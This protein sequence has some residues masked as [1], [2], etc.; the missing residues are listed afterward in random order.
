MR[1]RKKRIVAG[2][3]VAIMMA[4]SILC[5]ISPLRASET[6][7]N[8][9]VNEKFNKEGLWI[10]EIYQND[11]DRS[12]KNNSRE[13]SGYESIRLYKSTTDLMEFVEITSTYDK[14]VNFNDT[15]EFVYNDTALQ[16]STMDGS[17][18]VVIQPEEKVVLWNY[19]S[20]IKTPIPTEAEFREEMRIPDDAVVLKVTSEVNWGVTSTF[21]LRTKS[22]QNVIST[23][24]ATDKVDTMD[25]FSVEL[26]IPDIGNEMQVY[27]EMC[28]PSPGYIYSGQ[29][30]GLVK[31]KVPDSQIAD[32]V[33]ITEVRPNDVNRKSTYGIADDL[34][35][36]VEIVNTT[37]HDVDLNNE[38]QFGYE[39]KEGSRK[40]LELNH[41]DDNA[42]N[43]I[44][45]SDSCIIPAGKT[46]V[47][48]F[49]RVKFL[50]GYTSF[51]T[52]KEFRD[53]YKISD[54]V[55]V[56]LVTGQNGMN[57]TNRAV[58]L[59]KK[60]SDG[61][62]KLVSYY[63]YVG[64]SD[65]KDNKSAELM[66]NPEGPEM[67][68]K[69]AN[70]ATSMGSVS[71]AQYTY[72][73]DDGSA[74]GLALD[75]VVPSSI[76][77]G[78]EL[79]V[80]FRYDVTGSL[81]RTG[82]TTYYRFDGA[83]SWYS[84][85]EVN[86]RVPNLYESLIPAD[87]LFSHD[88]VEFYV[89][90]DNR[91]RSTYSDIYRVD[92]KKLNA[93]DGI[94][95]NITDNEQVRGIVSITANDGENNS[96]SKIYV[97]G[98]QRQTE[99]MLEDG[100]YFTFHAEG[101]DS[102]F[103]NAVTT[104]DN[105]VIAS[106]GKWQYQILDGQ[107]IHIDNRYFKYNEE[108]AAYDVTLRFWAGTY[109]AT[110]DEYLL[111]DANREDFTVKNLAL[112]LINGNIY[113]PKAIGPDNEDTSTKTNLSTDYETVHYIGDST[114]MCPYMDVSFTIPSSEVT[115]VG[116]QVDTTK[117][118]DG[119]HIL[120]VTNGTST[121]EVTF[122]VDN[123][124]PEIELGVN[125]GDVLRGNITLNP[126]VTETNTLDEFV[127]TLDGEQISDV[128]ETTSYALG[129]GVHTIA[130]FAKDAAGNETTK[131]ASFTVEGAQITIISGGTSD[132]TDNSASLYLN[133]KSDNSDTTTTFY[134]AEKIDT[135]SIKTN[136]S[137]GI[138]PYIQY[139]VNV[140]DVKDDEI[141]A[142]NWNG[143][144]SNSDGTHAGT[145]Y[146]LNTASN[147]WD[148]IAKADE[149][150][151]IKEASFTAANHVK[152]G[153]ATIIVQCTA[154]SALP[155]LDTVTD[156]KKDNNAS[157]D[158]TNV[159]EDYDFCFAWE[160]DTQ[161]YA[162]EWQHHFTNINNWI[163][164]NKD[165]RKIKYV[166]HTGDIVDDVD[167]TYEWE[168]ADAAMGILDKAGMPYGVLGGN[169]D[170]AAGLAD[171]E[172]YYK[173]FG[174]NR[175]ASQPT[176]GGTYQNN[177]GHYDLISEGGQDFIIVY[178]SWNIYQDEIDWMN[179]V[180]SQYSDRKAILCFHTYTNVKQ[181][182]GT[183]L[184]YYGQLVNKYVVKKNPNVF[185]VL[186]GHYHG[187]SYETAM[188]DDDG[189]GRNDRT[190]YQI[191][192]GYQSGFE[193]G[194]EYIKFLY[195]DL[196]N[197]KI[198]M[199]SYSPCMDDFNYYDTELH[200]LNVEGASATGVDQMVLDVDFDTKEQKIL[201]KSF[202]A[203]VYTNEELGKAVSTQ[204]AVLNMT[205]LSEN[206]DYA[207]YA[208]VT[209]ETTGIK[210]SSI[211]EFTT[212]K[213]N[214]SN[215]ADGENQN[216]ADTDKTGSIVTGDVSKAWIFALLGLTVSAAGA[217]IV[218][219]KKEA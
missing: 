41:Y 182:N 123:K 68:L 107:A 167:M 145:M 29:L 93:V 131:S 174:E 70:A 168:N 53:A 103:K 209:N 94:R 164:N 147:K 169:H 88:Y 87:E 208:V 67:I 129:D 120:K 99:P 157:W 161:Y 64:N 146:V 32:G 216:G 119:E 149:K 140:P 2:T 106:I 211:Y 134:K 206:T 46:A 162:E 39:V 151:N 118:S 98:V 175:F 17:S 95:T 45:S 43:G 35:E 193:G 201:E 143:E 176:Y 85:T 108:K 11:V 104:T 56:Y 57:N 155:E 6:G 31:A 156:K 63:A 42:E 159:P 82:I 75:D 86:R 214:D 77:Q 210:K 171:Y 138:L 71:E 152:D 33:F 150:G 186:N 10:T 18:D 212:A 116:T 90:A 44:G 84:T 4:G 141:I 91:Y 115:A 62:K 137:E 8:V 89:S 196:D 163:V 180:L 192:T 165:E 172:N 101:R 50:K 12:E 127:V 1:K 97:D 121:K 26:A 158:G 21:S 49:Y 207:W 38:Y 92:I 72:V 69:T 60:N 22:D 65:C 122:I 219:K 81:P 61:T 125:D 51:T 83:G 194:N 25:G 109:G 105:E 19:R 48:W 195:F 197:N 135:D 218:I 96:N 130:A 128:Y 139:T 36:C 187:S 66:V 199:N 117:L 73:K 181:S 144:A 102:Y 16:V 191:C 112:K 142:A 148:E 126:K 27:R 213:K 217:V 113:Y 80:N 9:T 111:P 15:Y 74:L 153:N 5:N 3:M 55:P 58:E 166:I 184:D 198:Y 177:K 23:F 52:E 185:A 170:V 28:E 200:T 13:T 133:V 24:T 40:I 37:D 215:I 203:Y 179:Q 160:T 189:D 14:P 79:R 76:M 100:A 178:M 7:G 204:N 132:V 110:V 20:D 188:F 173:Y 78:D 190:V 136:T 183:Y 47:I 154:D 202:S 59:Y 30:N 54:D 205:N 34:M 124:A 114:G